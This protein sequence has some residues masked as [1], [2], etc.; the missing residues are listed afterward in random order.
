MN[1]L[2]SF[3]GSNNSSAA[4]HPNPIDVVAF[5]ASLASKPE[6]IDPMLEDVRR[7]SSTYA[8][9]TEL[10]EPDQLAPDSNANAA[11]WQRVESTSD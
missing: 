2:K 1:W 3:L 8:P 4:Q 10:P 6:E 11:F 7:I 9:G 5:L